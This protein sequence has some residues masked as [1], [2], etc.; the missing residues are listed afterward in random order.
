M[1]KIMFIS[2]SLQL[3]DIASSYRNR[4]SALIS[5][6]AIRAGRQ[7]VRTLLEGTKQTTDKKYFGEFLKPGSFRRAF[8]DFDSVRPNNVREKM[9]KNGVSC[10]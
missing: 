9:F 5:H 2:P 6:S 8:D 4:R 1:Q 7:A 10:Y 3:A